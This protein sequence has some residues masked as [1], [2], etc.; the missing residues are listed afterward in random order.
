MNMIHTFAAIAAALLF[1]Q[2]AMAE[3]HPQALHIHDAFA[4]TMAKN[5]A[6][7]FTFHNN[8]DKEVVITGVTSDAAEKVELHTHQQD[9]A[10][11]MKMSKI[12]GGIAVPA[13]EIHEFARGA[14]HVMLMGLKSDL[15]EGA[16]VA[17]TLTFDGADPVTFEAMV[18][19]DAMKGGQDQSQMGQGNEGVG[20]DHAA[21]GHSHGDTKAP[22]IDTT[23]MTDDQAIAAIMKAQFETPES[24]LMVEPVV[25]QGDHAIASWAQD[26]KGGRALLERRDGV[27]TIV[28]CGGQDLR[29]PSFL[30]ENGVSDADALSALFNTT[31]EAL[32]ADK[33][34]LYSSFEGVVMIAPKH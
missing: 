1:A 4:L 23:G 6:V 32:G 10:G 7:F 2:S 17:I 19:G 31:E 3:D 20:N 12:E 33:V 5:G 34:Q 18:S 21:M 26:G 13:G 15:A 14:D 16:N 29:L 25:I 11:V 27:W 8:T 9:A 30:S 22:A 28:L 24:P